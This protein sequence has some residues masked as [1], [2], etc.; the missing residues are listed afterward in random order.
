M[1]N[2]LGYGFC[3]AIVDCRFFTWFAVAG[4]LLGSVLCFIEVYM[5]QISS[6]LTCTSLKIEAS[7]MT[8]K[9]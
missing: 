8:H 7:V 9:K 6:F 5:Q 3:Q 1:G 2:Q 4:S